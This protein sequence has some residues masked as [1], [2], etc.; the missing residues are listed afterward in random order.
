MK[1]ETKK[2]CNKINLFMNEGYMIHHSESKI[3]WKT[4]KDSKFESDIAK[5]SPGLEDLEWKS[6]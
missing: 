4:L 1:I 5:S 3:K 2:K 6:Y